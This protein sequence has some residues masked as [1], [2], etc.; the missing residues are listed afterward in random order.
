M[1]QLTPGNSLLT[2]P[3]SVDPVARRIKVVTKPEKPSAAVVHGTVPSTV[4]DLEYDV[5]VMG[6][7]ARA[8]TFGIQGVEEH[9]QFLKE[10]SDARGIRKGI[11]ECAAHTH[12]HT[13]TVTATATQSM[14]QP[15]L[16]HSVSS[17]VRVV[18][19]AWK[20]LLTTRCPRRRGSACCTGWLLVAALLAL[21]SRGSCQTLFTRYRRGEGEGN[22]PPERACSHTTCCTVIIRT[23]AGTTLR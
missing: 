18:S 16:P 9:V 17:L 21:S 11:T 23:C 10:L 13:V 15:V 22:T 19:G 8:N 14:L 12:S 3:L 4:Y 6:V 7:G 1:A 5:L 2:P 20:R